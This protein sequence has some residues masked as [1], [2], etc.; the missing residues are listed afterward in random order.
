MGA[1]GTLEGGIT[2]LH[3]RRGKGERKEGRLMYNMLVWRR[4][5]RMKRRR[6]REEEEQRGKRRK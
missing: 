5:R 1:E 6:R 4:I 2:P 3:P